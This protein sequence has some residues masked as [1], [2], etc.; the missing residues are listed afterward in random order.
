MRGASM[1]GERERLLSLR[2]RGTFVPLP[3]DKIELVRG[4]V[5]IRVIRGRIRCDGDSSRYDF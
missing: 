1:W 3:A 4:S 5:F 2:R